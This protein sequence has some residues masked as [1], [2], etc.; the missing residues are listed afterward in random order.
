MSIITF[1]GKKLPA[2]VAQIR[3]DS[4]DVADALYGLAFI[5]RG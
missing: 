5:Y 2:F 1:F 3:F 4:K